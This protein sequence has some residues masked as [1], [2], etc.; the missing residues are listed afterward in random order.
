VIDC[1]ICHVMN[2]D[3]ARFCAE[4]GQRLTPGAQSAPAA[5]APATAPAPGAM[6]PQGG[7]PGPGGAYGGAM[8]NQRPGAPSGPQ[9]NPGMAPN[10][11]AQPSRPAEPPKPAHKLHSPLLGDPEPPAEMHDGRADYSRL[12]G[13]GRPGAAPEPPA[14]GQRRGLHSP[15]LGDSYDEPPAPV[16]PPS[17]S[18]RRKGL[19]SPLLQ[20]DDVEDYIDTQPSRGTKPGKGGGL[21]SPLLGGMD[22][23]EPA[24]SKRGGHLHSPLLGGGSDLDYDAPAKPRNIG[25]SSKKPHLHSPILGDVFDDD[26]D[27]YGNG[28]NVDD[29]NV[30][31]SPLLAAKVPLTEKPLPAKNVRVPDR[32]V[33]EWSGVASGPE[34]RSGPI[35]MSGPVQPAPNP[36]AA[37]AQAAPT[38]FD[39]APRQPPSDFGLGDRGPGGRGMGD[40]GFGSRA[41]ETAASPRS[42]M[43]DARPSYAAPSPGVSVSSA[44]GPAPVEDFS[45]MNKPAPAPS[46]ATPLPEMSSSIT[47]KRT[48][49]MLAD[50]DTDTAPASSRDRYMSAPPSQPALPGMLKIFVVPLAGAVLL[51]GY[52]IVQYMSQMQ[53]VLDQAAQLVAFLVLIIICLNSGK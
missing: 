13:A 14:G 22:D 1:P 51:K 25:G 45:P 53:V 19:H 26:D 38:S 46:P 34:M 7:M 47:R 41:E 6:Q 49:R 21:R 12:R 37:S 35:S 5:A 33:D 2:E 16:D 52:L 40:S 17:G 31:R 29:P 48:S 20:G 39:T 8:P 27:D 36:I 15:L 18:G 10:M 3:M 11:G 9:P 30:L 23:D 42:S 32:V 50:D 4:C 28:S 44:P 43:A 24:P